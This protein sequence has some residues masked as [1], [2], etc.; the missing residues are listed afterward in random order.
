VSFFLTFFF[1]CS[2]TSY[3]SEEVEKIDTVAA[4]HKTDLKRETEVQKPE[5]KEEPV[6]IQ[7]KIQ[8]KFAIQIGAFQLESNAIEVMSKAQ[9]LLSYK[10]YYKLLS[11]L[12]KVRLGE[13]DSI[14]EALTIIDTIKNSGF[15]DSFIVE[16]IKSK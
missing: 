9:S 3:D 5:I 1:S 11:G 6:D 10:I 12:Y 8:K 15:S 14:P 2:S 4:P 13:F 16:I 7:P